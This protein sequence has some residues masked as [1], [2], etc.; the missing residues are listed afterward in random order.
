MKKI[1][2][3][4]IIFVAVL[5]LSACNGSD[6]NTE[7]T[8]SNEES[9]EITLGTT[10]AEHGHPFTEASMKF[11][12][13]VEENSDG[14]ITVDVYPNSQLGGDR[15]LSESVLSGT[16][17]MAVIT[18]DGAIANWIPE[19]QIFTIPY[20]IDGKENS[21]ELLDADLGDFLT[22]RAEEEGFKNLGFWELG[23]RHLTNDV[24]PINEPEDFEGIKFRVM[25][26]PVWIEFME[27]VGAIPT[28]LAFDEVYSSLDQGVV[29]G[30]INPPLSILSNGFEEVQD[31]LTLDAQSLTPGWVV[32]NPNNWEQ[33]SDEQ[34][35][36]IESAV[37]ESK[38]YIRD[39]LDTEEESAIQ[40]LEEAGMEVNEPN[41]EAL[42]EA[43]ENVGQDVLDLFPESLLDQI[44]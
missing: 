29:D 40:Q 25:E 39:W 15:E 14:E 4:S 3:N 27:T 7:A 41:R 24:R 16:V 36:I 13:I 11:K 38:V 35:S 18:G 32:Y 1:I 22:Q 17:D 34:K 20:F 33:L 8:G 6:E 44:E 23:L 30:Q 9:V 43:T 10:G 19:S 42:R 26:A 28:P 5:T 2:I 12:E 31:Y 21:R 37:E